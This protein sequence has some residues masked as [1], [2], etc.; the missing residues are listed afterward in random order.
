MRNELT[1]W[2]A[3]AFKPQQIEEYLGI[4]R[5]GLHTEAVKHVE[6]PVRMSSIPCLKADRAVPR[7]PAGPLGAKDLWLL[8]VSLE[9]EMNG[10]SS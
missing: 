3:S 9:T 6:L 5:V 10:Q 8:T 1:R 2:D 4:L 7:R